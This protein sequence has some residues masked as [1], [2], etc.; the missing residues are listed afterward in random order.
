MKKILIAAVAVFVA[1]SAFG[2]NKKEEKT[3]VYKD[4]MY[5][6]KSAIDEWGG[7]VT[8]DI[9]VKDG[10]ITDVV[11]GN[12]DAGGK[13]KDETYGMQDGEIKNE[14]LY[15]I[16]QNAVKFSTEYP[17]KLIEKQDVEKIDVISGATVTL[18]SFKEAV[19]T[20]LKDAKE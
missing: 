17:S 3:V 13:E 9:T 18:N 11:L 10:K 7:Y 16:A 8:A 6:G 15:N 12:F 4:G 19:N 20:A 1:V 5:Q 2:C 14:G